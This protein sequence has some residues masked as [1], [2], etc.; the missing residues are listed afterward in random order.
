MLRL[1][2]GS[3]DAGVTTQDRLHSAELGIHYLRRYF[4]LICFSGFLMAHEPTS[5]L[6]SFAGWMKHHG[7]LQTLLS[8]I[9]FE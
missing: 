8:A 3:Q 2:R 5:G 1:K 9:S 4:V 6:G 7:E